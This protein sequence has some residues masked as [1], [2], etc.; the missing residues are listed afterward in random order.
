[1][2]QCGDTNC[3]NFH[4]LPCDYM[5]AVDPAEQLFSLPPLPC[6]LRQSRR[7]GG[8]VSDPWPDA[9]FWP[10]ARRADIERHRLCLVLLQGLR[11]APQRGQ[12]IRGLFSLRFPIRRAAH[13][14]PWIARNF[15][16]VG[17]VPEIATSRLQMRNST[18]Q[19]ADAWHMAG[20]RHG[21]KV[22]HK[23]ERLVSIRI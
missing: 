13:L 9:Q 15:V 18:S 14:L 23:V 10:G 19:M 21:H 20:C 7:G 16:I 12:H 2:W 4:Q 3:T 17:C 1:V 22:S 5:K 6:P 11:T 8:E